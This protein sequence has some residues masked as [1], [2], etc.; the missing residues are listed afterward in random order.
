MPAPSQ[1]LR[2][3]MSFSLVLLAGR[4]ARCGSLGFDRSNSRLQSGF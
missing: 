2:L 3:C 4:M 1:R